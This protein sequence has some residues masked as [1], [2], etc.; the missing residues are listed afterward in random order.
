MTLLF[1]VAAAQ[2]QGHGAH[3]GA[4]YTKSVLKQLLMQGSGVQIAGFFDPQRPLGKE[5][6]D[7]LASRVSLHPAR[8][9]RELERLVRKLR[10]RRLFTALPYDYAGLQCPDVDVVVTIHG[11]RTVEMPADRYAAKCA[12][13][14]VEACKCWARLLLRQPYRRWQEHGFRK[15]TALTARR[16]TF[17]VP[18]EYT[19]CSLLRSCPQVAPEDVLTLYSPVTS[20]AANEARQRD[21]P[22][23]LGLTDRRYFL[24]VSANRWVKNSF[25]ALQAIEQVYEHLPRDRRWPVVLTGGMPR[26]FPRRWSRFVV[27]LSHL[28]TLQLA[29]LYASAGALVYPSLNEGFG[30]PPIEAMSYGTPVLAAAIS[31]VPEIAAEG[32]AYF[33]PY[34]VGDIA[35][36]IH[37]FL[38]SAPRELLSRAA[39][40]RFEAVNARQVDDL[41]ALISLLLSGL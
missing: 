26:R 11:L 29:A 16:R 7:L 12:D 25:R 9:T 5:L 27:A 2:P 36:R 3:G 17:V 14:I 15:L 39:H 33:C 28:D 6:E 32:A 31:A 35:T 22:K 23:S 30:Y 4:E 41:R 34:D 20:A 18:S 37:W 40:A 8:N 1:D 21:F 10:P 38:T 19:R 24:L 13:D